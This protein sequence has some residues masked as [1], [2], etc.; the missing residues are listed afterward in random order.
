MPDE[1]GEAAWFAAQ[2]Q[3]VV[4]LP[5][6]AAAGEA[7][8]AFVRR[9]VP[10]HAELADLAATCHQL[11]MDLPIPRAFS[12]ARFTPAN[13]M[14][15]RDA[16]ARLQ[17]DPASYA[18]RAAMEPLW[19]ER[20]GSPLLREARQFPTITIVGADD[21]LRLARVACWRR[22]M[23][24]VQLVEGLRA[25]L[26]VLTGFAANDPE[27]AERAIAPGWLADRAVI[28]DWPGDQLR[29]RRGAPAGTP[30]HRGLRIRPAADALTASPVAPERPNKKRHREIME[31][32]E[33]LER[34]GDK[35]PSEKALHRAVLQRLN[36]DDDRGGYSYNTFVRLL[37]MRREGVAP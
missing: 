28:L 27:R 34:D 32:V 3:R 30:H 25:G 1:I 26:Y 29:P 13:A 2:M 6:A 11:D 4:E 8:S 15:A 22:D 10:Q 7:L 24:I 18:F 23:L 19:T 14:R 12:P 5:P 9:A 31:A 21:R 20:L 36:R 16:R 33:Q 37:A 17:G 35:F